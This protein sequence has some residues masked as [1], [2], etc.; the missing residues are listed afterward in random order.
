VDPVEA[1][2]GFNDKLLINVKIV[3]RLLCL[4]QYIM[5]VTESY[6]FLADDHPKS[7][8][9]HKCPYGSLTRLIA[10]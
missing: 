5:Y 2:W 10:S 7:W 3:V 9:L 4:H 6:V 1:L 8:Q